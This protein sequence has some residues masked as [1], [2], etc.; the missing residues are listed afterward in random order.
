MALGI[1]ILSLREKEFLAETPLFEQLVMTDGYAGTEAYLR[2]EPY[3]TPEG[4]LNRK[5]Y[6]R[7]IRMGAK[8]ILSIVKGL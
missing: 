6:W 1:D 2:T 8:P 4:E 7:C 3:F 5:F